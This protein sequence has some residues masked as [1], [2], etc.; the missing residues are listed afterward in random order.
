MPR[1]KSLS[2][3]VGGEAMLSKGGDFNPCATTTVCSVLVR[4]ALASGSDSLVGSLGPGHC[5][6]RWALAGRSVAVIA[7]REFSRTLLLRS[8]PPLGAGPAARAHTRTQDA[9]RAP[10]TAAF[11]RRRP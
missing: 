8:S 1:G 10:E 2:A 3:G 7:R 5:R 11:S 4:I 6:Q 9:L